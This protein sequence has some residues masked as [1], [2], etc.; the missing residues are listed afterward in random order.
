[1]RNMNIPI[2]VALILLI[3]DLNYIHEDGITNPRH[4]IKSLTF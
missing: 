1:M 3:G 4:Q 2:M